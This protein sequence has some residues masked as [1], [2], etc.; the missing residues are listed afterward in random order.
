MT[1]ITL[2]PPRIEHHG[3]SSWAG[4]LLA[5]VLEPPTIVAGLDDLAVM[6]D[7][8]QE[9]RGHLGVAKDLAPLVKV[10]LIVTRTEVRS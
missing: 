8:I 4:G 5:S 3:F 2:P 7:P 1:G 6:G 10:R 9:R